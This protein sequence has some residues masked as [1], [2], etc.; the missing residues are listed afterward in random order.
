MQNLR[1]KNKYLFLE[2]KNK[3]KKLW[4]ENFFDDDKKTINYF[5]ENVLENKKGVG[6]FFE[7][8]LIAMVL[9]LD[10]EIILKENVKK[11]VYFYAVCTDVKFRNKGVIKNLITFAKKMLEEQNTEIAFLV[12]ANEELFSMYEKFCFSKAIGYNETIF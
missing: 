6:A 7:D 9:F 8:E 4:L 10:S 1:I 11:S 5:L 2:D 3:I 12:P